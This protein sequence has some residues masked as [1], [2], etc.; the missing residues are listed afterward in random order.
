MDEI[1]TQP[2]RSRAPGRAAGPNG[3]R[4]HLVL[5]T[6][7]FF[8]ARRPAYVVSVSVLVIAGIFAADVATDR[9]L[10]P[11]LLYLLPVGL[12][13]W[14]LGRRG[15]VCVAG[16]AAVA[17]TVSDVVSHV[18]G[19]DGLAPAWTLVTRLAVL[20]VVSSLLS[21]IRTTMRD[22]RELADE[23]IDAA[24][25]LRDIN[26]VKDTLLHAISHDLRGAIAAVVG[27]AH[28]LQRRDSLA[29]SRD[30]EDVL[31]E[32]I[33]LSGRKLDRTVTDLLDLERLDRGVVTPD[34]SATDVGALV[35]R[36]IDELPP[37]RQ[38]PVDVEI[39]EAIVS[40][41]DPALV[42]RILEN[43]L[44]NAAKHTPA[45]TRIAVCVT[46]RPGGVLVRVEDEGPG[47]PEDLKSVI[48]Q[49]FRQGVGVRSGAGI[50]LSLV[51]K[52]A[53]LHGGWAWVE[54]RP[55]GGAVFLVFLP[56]GT[57][58][59]PTEPSRAASV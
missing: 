9:R 39:P 28:S 52:F 57:G 10:S 27:S 5:S 3:R 13:T 16:L 8:A 41:V 51:G 20:S 46:R 22:Q 54:D 6:E 50:G 59:V 29:L 15:G 38:H 56:G 1:G 21:T 11:S 33:L 53:G 14:R 49:P 31:I 25:A 58:V 34:R 26:D 42:E 43:L 24:D 7:G 17:W 45:G 36:V 37:P 23:A 44:A 32:G 40:Q 18:H 55:G 19:T 48:F 30:D 35:R 2:G 12:T 47:V 4:Y